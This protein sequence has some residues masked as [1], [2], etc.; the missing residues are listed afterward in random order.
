MRLAEQVCAIWGTP[1]KVSAISNVYLVE[2]PRCG[3]D[4]RITREASVNL[5]SA[6]E[7]LRLNATNWLV[8]QFLLGAF[9]PTIT[10]TIL[11]QIAYAAPPPIPERA[12]RLLHFIA[13]NSESLGHYVPIDDNHD[14]CAA[15]AWGGVAGWSEVEFLLDFLKVQGF[16]TYVSP[17][18]SSMMQ[19]SGS[20]EDGGLDF[21]ESQFRKSMANAVILP[22][23]Y[24]YLENQA[25]K[26]K[27][28]QAF[29]AM[30]F[31]DSMNEAYNS[32][33]YLGID[34]A[35]YDPVRIDRQEHNEKIDDRIIAEISRSRFLVADFT[36]GENGMRGGVYYEAGFAHGLRIPVIFTCKADVIDKVH[37]DTRQYNHITWSTPEE[38]REKLCNRICATIG[39]G[40]KRKR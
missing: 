3:G 16:L 35:G 21:K 11:E 10:T 1:A 9:E 20:I 18:Y 23:G 31:D 15:A 30:W 36:H 34:D 38:L 40:P 14:S 25:E 37:F 28:T 33:I 4:Y 24:A 5:R 32:G 6:S 12:V 7:G 29:V 8:G 13:T 26:Q 17:S 19:M 22:A 2:S 39:D 27:P